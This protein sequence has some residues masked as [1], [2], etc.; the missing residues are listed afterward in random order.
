MRDTQDRS[1]GSTELRISDL[2]ER[3]Q[4]KKSP[5][6]GLGKKSH[7][8]Q[9]RLTGNSYCG[10]LYY[11]A[12]FIPCVNLKGISFDSQPNELMAAIGSSARSSTSSESSNSDG[13]DISSKD[14]E[15]IASKGTSSR[16]GEAKDNV[17]K[18][19][20]TGE[21]KDPTKKEEKAEVT[22]EEEEAGIEMSKEELL[23]CRE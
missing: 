1:L 6:V 18:Y 22:Q 8:D 2:V 17:D 9:L 4:D 3:R 5:Y 19:V 13:V 7:E 15:S 23:D 14:V 16:P 10:T 12:E 11:D 21:K 20:I